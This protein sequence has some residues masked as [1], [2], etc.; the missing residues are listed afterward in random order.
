MKKKNWK[1]HK[2]KVFIP[3]SRKDNKREFM[4]EKN[5]KQNFLI[6]LIK[7]RKKRNNIEF[8]F[9]FVYRNLGH[10]NSLEFFFFNME[11]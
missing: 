10:T 4:L 8:F 7:S 1:K 3:K 9:I 2:H 6:Q 11:F 5:T